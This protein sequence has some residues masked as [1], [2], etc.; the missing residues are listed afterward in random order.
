MMLFLPCGFKL[1]SRSPAY[2]AEVQA[3]GEEAERNLLAFAVG[4]ESSGK[5]VGTD[6]AFM[7]ELKRTSGLSSLIAAHK[8]LREKGDAVEPTPSAALPKFLRA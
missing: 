3:L 2:K 7:Q 5:V 1:D 6:V 4:R 8:Q